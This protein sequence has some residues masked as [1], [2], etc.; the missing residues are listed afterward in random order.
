M[1]RRRPASSWRSTRRVPHVCSGIRMLAAEVHQK[2]AQ[3]E[4]VP[5]VAPQP[6]GGDIIA[7]HAPDVVDAAGQTS[8]V[9]AEFGGNDCGEMLVLGNSVDFLFREIGKGPAVPERNTGGP[10]LTEA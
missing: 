10:R 7:D 3:S 1:I 6:R 2:Q 8:Q 5:L 9:I 4:R